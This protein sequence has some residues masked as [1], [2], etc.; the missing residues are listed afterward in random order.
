MGPGSVNDAAPETSESTARA[1][2]E[3]VLRVLAMRCTVTVA[4]APGMTRTMAPERRKSRT[5]MPTSLAAAPDGAARR[6]G[7]DGGNSV[8]GV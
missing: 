8:A 4:G 3:S 5:C 2:D 1:A 6:R 7:C